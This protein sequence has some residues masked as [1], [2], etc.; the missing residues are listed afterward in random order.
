MKQFTVPLL[1]KIVYIFFVYLMALFQLP[2]L[3]SVGLVIWMIINGESWDILKEGRRKGAT[4][5]IL[6]HS[7]GV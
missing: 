3:Y 2:T 6:N 1:S 7:P 4:L 5:L